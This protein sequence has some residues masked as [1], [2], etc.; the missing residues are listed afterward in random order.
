MNSIRGLSMVNK[1]SSLKLGSVVLAVVVIVWWLLYASAGSQRARE[2]IIALGLA[3]LAIIL[4][5][6]SFAA[7]WA[8]THAVNT[9]L[10]FSI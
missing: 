9:T 8:A 2:N 10:K 5:V 3:L 1:S 7:V 4:V 6:A